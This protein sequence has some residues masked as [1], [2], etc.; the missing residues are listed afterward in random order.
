MFKR[1]ELDRAGSRRA[2]LRNT[3]VACAEAAIASGGLSAL[4]ARDLA[5]CVGCSLGAIYNLVEDLDEL[6]LLVGRRTMA[7]L[8]DHLDQAA[9]VRDSSLEGQLIGW[10]HAYHRF[11][12]AHRHRWHALFEFRTTSRDDLPEWFADAQTKLFVRLE[13]RLAPVMSG[14]DELVL[15]RRAR[16]LFS[17]VHGIV[18]IGLERKLVAFPEDA[19]DAE[20]AAFIHIYLAGLGATGRDERPS[21]LRHEVD[22]EPI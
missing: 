2:D 18:L 13:R 7:A 19:I 1:Y 15:K 14:I 6:V 10:A 4:K 5:R 20:L 9:S 3:L 12:A 11:A 22:G 16:T 17:A 8:D 21:G